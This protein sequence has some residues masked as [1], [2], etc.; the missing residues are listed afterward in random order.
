MAIE[1]NM[2][3][4]LQA[5]DFSQKRDLY[6]VLG[7]DKDWPDPSSPSPES[8]TTTMIE[9]PLAVVKVDRLVLCYKTDEHVPDSASDGD[10]FV[11]YKGSKW[12]TIRSDQVL[13]NNQLLQPANYV[14]L[15]GTLDVAKLPMFSFTQIGVAEDVVIADNAP[16][17]HEAQKQNV[18][19]WG[20]MY[21]YENR[22]ME[23]YGNTQRKIMKYMIQF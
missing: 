7:R 5:I 6:F 16:S 19:N 11:I 20:N 13:S 3:H 4:V 15:I 23:T 18:T 12:K 2:G 14:C 9:N 21:F 8:V 22:P 17:K 10:D 1:T